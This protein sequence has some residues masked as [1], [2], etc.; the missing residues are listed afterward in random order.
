VSRFVL[1]PAARTDLDEIWDYTC[2]RWDA[3]QAERYLREVQHT[4]ERAAVDPLIGRPCDEI[5]AGY[6]R[7]ATGS[8][9]IY[10]RIPADDTI[11]VVRIL[12]Q[13]MDVGRNL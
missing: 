7:L 5:R 10:F 9:H 12:H 8:H 3:D 6:R 2:E 13:R 11:E 4:I 1:S